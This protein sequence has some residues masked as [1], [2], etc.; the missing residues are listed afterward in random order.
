MSIL[1]Q[2][3]ENKRQ[4]V[5]TRKLLVPVADMILRAEDA[6]RPR[7]FA[8]AIADHP[9]KPALIAEVKK[10]SPSKGVI[11]EDFDPERIA[12]AY[13][14]GGASCI[15]VLT[16]ERYF[17]GRLEY[18]TR[19]KEA[20]S[21]PVLCKD[22]ILEPYQIYEAVV[23]GAD[24]ILLI[25]RAFRND[26][27][28]LA[29]LIWTAIEYDLDTLVEV[30]DA[31]DLRLVE[32]CRFDMLGINNRDLDT[33]HTDLAVTERLAGVAPR[34]ALIVAESGIET[35]EDLR[36]LSRSGVSAILV[37]ESLMRQPDVEAATRKL[38]GR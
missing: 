7:G 30:H 10:A 21:L 6:P 16:D 3:L 35:H 31:E 8:K 29:D 32:G 27:D 23:A 36:R 22:F 12:E 28:A 2:I 19:V 4:E 11:R 18:L 38:L 34:D 14:R 17:Q 33:F 20:V 1:E 25:A 5:I 15:S 13:E 37:G 24:A 9:S 26:P